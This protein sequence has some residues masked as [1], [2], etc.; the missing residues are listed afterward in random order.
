MK[1]KL[2][3]VWDF[4]VTKQ[5]LFTWADGLNA[6]LNIL[7]EKY[8]YEVYVISSDNKASIEEQLRAIKPDVILGWGSL[9]RPS[10]ASLREYKVPTAL[11]FAGG[12]TTHP[13]SSSFDIVFVENDVYKNAFVRQGVNVKVAF[14]TN[15]QLFVPIQ[16]KEHYRAF[17]PAAFALWKRH[18]LFAKA[19]GKE[20]IACGK[21]IEKERSC[22]DVCVENGVT[23]LPQL[24]YQ[25]LP[26]LYNQS[27]YTLITASSAGGS[28]R[29]VL[30]SMSCEKIPIVMSD[31]EKCCEYVKDSGYGVIVEP[32]VE[33]IK[34]A[35]AKEYKFDNTGRSYIL[36]KYSAEIYAKQIH[37]GLISIR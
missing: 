11:C 30:E 1:T 31:S 10:F 23:V 5:E 35:L 36:S 13:F 27:K 33:A 3:F 18:E 26:Y 25:V 15:S 17:Y 9:D 29:A 16:L 37:E 7:Q 22:I 34:E 19:V 28:Q 20:G 32:K 4:A 6:A 2:A 8:N 14:G 21:F 24:P 12:P